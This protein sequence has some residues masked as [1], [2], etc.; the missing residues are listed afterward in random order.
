MHKS[1]F[2]RILAVAGIVLGV[3]VAIFL[4]LVLRT[5]MQQQA[6][7]SKSSAPTALSGRTPTSNAS[8][9]AS[10]SISPTPTAI[11]TPYV[12]PSTIISGDRGLLVVA[13][14]ARLYTLG[15]YP[16]KPT[17]Y[18]AGITLTAVKNFQAANN[19]YVDGIVSKDTLSV[20]FSN[21]VKYATATPVPLPT[22]TPPNVRPREYGQPLLFSK[23][24]TLM[25]SGSRFLV[26]D[27]NSQYY[28]YAIRQ[29]GTSHMEIVPA[30]QEDMQRYLAIFA[31]RSSLEKRPC[32][33]EFNGQNI[34]ASLCGFLHGS[35]SAQTLDLYFFGSTANDSQ[36]E[37]QEHNANLL[38]SSNGAKPQ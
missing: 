6:G 37:D 24:N 5:S 2:M 29:G 20:L 28:F 21:E 36:L 14:Q 30:S 34:A 32:V 17:G 11:P 16:Y 31:G 3:L 9:G 26:V 10:G 23:V 4:L 19:L 33:V 1:Q 12:D 18:F 22:A 8:A 27:L 25:P 35:D 15:Y 7:V 13:V 38:L